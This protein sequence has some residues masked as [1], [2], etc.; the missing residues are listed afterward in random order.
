VHLSW[1]KEL[2][3]KDIHKEM[4]PVYVGKRRRAKR[5]RL[6]GKYYADDE[7]VESR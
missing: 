5:F 2:N 1:A 3:A 4:L 7:E 6:G